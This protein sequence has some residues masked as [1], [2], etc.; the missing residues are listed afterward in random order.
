MKIADEVLHQYQV[1]NRET[2]LHNR[3]K[4][5]IHTMS[6]KTPV[7]TLWL[8]EDD[9][10]LIKAFLGFGAEVKGHI[11]Q[12]DPVWLKAQM[13]VWK[14]EVLSEPLFKRIFNSDK[15]RVLAE[16]EKLPLFLKP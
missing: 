11:A 14:K 9:S 3:A 2:S 5:T 1:D 6:K 15:P 12:P 13:S 4:Y 7:H 8:F 10:Y 16:M